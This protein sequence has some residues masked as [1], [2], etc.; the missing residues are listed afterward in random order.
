MGG[1]VTAAITKFPRRTMVESCVDPI[2]V[3]I[4]DGEANIRARRDAKIR[5]H[6][7]T[8]TRTEV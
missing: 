6:K 2:V 4:G 7:L 8:Q 1:T 5:I 3:R